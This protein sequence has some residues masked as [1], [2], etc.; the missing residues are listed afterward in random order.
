MK[1]TEAEACA[2]GPRRGAPL[3][4]HDFAGQLEPLVLAVLVQHMVR[5]AA[6]IVRQHVRPAEIK[7]TL[8]ETGEPHAGY[9]CEARHLCSSR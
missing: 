9:V 6:T 4:R 3:P 1:R 5:T 2:E 8:R 7:E